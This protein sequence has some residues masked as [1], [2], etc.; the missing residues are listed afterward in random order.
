MRWV[1]RDNKAATSKT[2]VGWVEVEKLQSAVEPVSSSLLSVC[3]WDKTHWITLIQVMEHKSNN[4]KHSPCQRKK[5]RRLNR[6]SCS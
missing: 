4:N 3:S 1:G 5:I 2:A 6:E